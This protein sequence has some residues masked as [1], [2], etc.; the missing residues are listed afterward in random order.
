[1]EIG[2]NPGLA[3]PADR[4]AT[5]PGDEPEEVFDVT[6]ADDEAMEPSRA[7]PAARVN[8]SASRHSEEPLPAGI[9]PE[10]APPRGGFR[11]MDRFRGGSGGGGA[12]IMVRTV[13]SRARTSGA[14]SPTLFELLECKRL[15]D[16]TR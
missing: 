2:R 6:D 4:A 8:A 7:E 15:L 3:I 10:G 9:L 13:P 16:Q 5:E 11:F 1:M 12:G 14:C